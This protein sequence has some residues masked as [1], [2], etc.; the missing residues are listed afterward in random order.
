MSSIT[1]TVSN[2][3]AGGDHA[4]ITITGDMALTTKLN[5]PE[6]LMPITEEDKTTFMVLLLRLAKKTRTKAQL[7]ADLTTG[8]TVTI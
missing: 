1:L 8:L 6:L 2:P 5:V 4:T 7:K 3:C